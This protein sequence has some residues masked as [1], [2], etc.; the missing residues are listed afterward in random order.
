MRWPNGAHCPHCNHSRIYRLKDDKTY[1]CG[2]CKKCFSAT[3]GTIF[4]NSK[5]PIQTCVYAIALLCERGGRVG[6]T[7]LANRLGLSQKSAWYLL[8]KLQNATL[9]LSFQK[10]LRSQRN[11]Q[12]RNHSREELSV[13]FKTEPR[14]TKRKLPTNQ[15]SETVEAVLQKLNKRKSAFGWGHPSDADMAE[16]MFKPLITQ[17]YKLNSSAIYKWAREHGWEDSEASELEDVVLTISVNR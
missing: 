13:G 1:K 9:T 14:D 10:P 3:V 6:S 11:Y 5:L 2:N 4:E 7:E 8:E 17:G 16:T 15:L 12:R